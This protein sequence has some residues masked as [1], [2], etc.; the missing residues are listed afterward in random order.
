[1]E[2]LKTA[3]FNDTAL[4]VRLQGEAHFLRGY[5][6]QQLLRYYGA[7]PIISSSYGLNEDYSVARN[8]YE[9][10]V[11]FII[12]DCDSA[13][14]LL[15]GKSLANGRATQIS[16]LALKSRVL[17]YAASDLHDIPTAK[18]KSATISGFCQS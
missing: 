11:N 4:N 6:Y 10:C 13:A 16:A 17:L 12:S 18:A 9:E 5:Y 8:T 15:A 2:N 7:I 14:L 1:M 3:T